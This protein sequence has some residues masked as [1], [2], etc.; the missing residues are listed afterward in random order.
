MSEHLAL[1]VGSQPPLEA[2]DLPRKGPAWDPRPPLSTQHL[3]QVCKSLDDEPV[4][5]SGPLG[6]TQ[7]VQESVSAQGRNKVKARERTYIIAGSNHVFYLN[8]DILLV[9]D[10]GGH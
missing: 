8:F 3:L 7:H 9:A 10:F 4:P 1:T 2:G 5:R 6:D